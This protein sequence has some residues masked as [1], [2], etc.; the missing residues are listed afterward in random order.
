ME[1]KP[2]LSLPASLLLSLPPSLLSASRFLCLLFSLSVRTRHSRHP[3]LAA[4]LHF[5]IRRD[6]PRSASLPPLVAPFTAQ[7]QAQHT[8]LLSTLWQRLLPLLSLTGNHAGS[9]CS[10]HDEE[11]RRLA[12]NPRWWWRVTPQSLAATT[13]E[14]LRGH[15]SSQ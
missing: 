4:T 11:E 5:P 14:H 12:S 9:T 8:S 13:A 3:M 1:K 6:L 7:P 10:P 15:A 2:N